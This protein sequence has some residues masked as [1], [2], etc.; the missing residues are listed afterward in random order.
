M[1]NLLI[2]NVQLSVYAGERSYL[3]HA[4]GNKPVKFQMTVTNN[5]VQRTMFICSSLQPGHQYPAQCDNKELVHLDTDTSLIYP[6]L[7]TALRRGDI[8]L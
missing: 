6:P 1:L 2:C 8:Y 5:I 4:N 3:W 7:H